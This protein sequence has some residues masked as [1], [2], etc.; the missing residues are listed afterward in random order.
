[1]S[2]NQAI[3]L[4][5]SYIVMVAMSYMFVLR[6]LD[7]LYLKHNRHPT[8]EFEAVCFFAGALIWPIGLPLSLIYIRR[9]RGIP[10]HVRIE[11]KWSR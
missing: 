6:S 11:G 7:K 1:M 5:M 3:A 4:V 9:W 2:A 10:D 8:P